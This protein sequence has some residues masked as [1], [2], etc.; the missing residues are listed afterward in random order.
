MTTIDPLRLFCIH[1]LHDIYEDAILSSCVAYSLGS[2]LCHIE[3]SKDIDVKY[4]VKI[5]RSTLNGW[6]YERYSSI[7][8][9][10]ETTNTI[11][12]IDRD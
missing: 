9:K 4:C 12:S 8:R 6:L 5:F 3:D 11:A 10:G 7:L 2:G 1:I